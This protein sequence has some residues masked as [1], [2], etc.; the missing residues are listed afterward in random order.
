MYGN[1]ILEKKSHISCVS[2]QK[3]CKMSINLEKKQPFTF[4][5][6]G[7]LII[8]TL[9]QNKWKNLGQYEKNFL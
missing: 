2:F 8:Y 6:K 3:Q 7:Y 1:S 4:Y 9:Y 5:Y